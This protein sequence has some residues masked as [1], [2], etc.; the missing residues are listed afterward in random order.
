MPATDAALMLLCAFRRRP[1][2]A[3][4]RAMSSLLPSPRCAAQRRPRGKCPAPPKH[5]CARPA[6]AIVRISKIFDIL[7]PGSAAHRAPV[8]CAVLTR[9][10][11]SREGRP[12]AAAA[13]TGLFCRCA[14]GL[15]ARLR[16]CPV[17]CPTD[18]ACACA[19][20]QE[21]CAIIYF[22]PAHAVDT[23]GLRAP[24]SELD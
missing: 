15:C 21:V 22:P 5:V 1:R 16:T 18:R 14:C 9:L 11:A 24:A 7:L 6:Q 8:P 20:M 17:A 3:W 23:F 13:D 10:G 12:V 4:R 2:R 19:E